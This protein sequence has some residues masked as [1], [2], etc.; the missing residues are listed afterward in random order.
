MSNERTF[1]SFLNLFQRNQTPQRNVVPQNNDD[2]EE[3]PLVI[4]E[5][6]EMKRGRHENLPTSGSM[7]QLPVPSQFPGMPSNMP[8]G[9]NQYMLLQVIIYFPLCFHRKILILFKRMS[10]YQFPVMPSNV[11]GSTNTCCFGYVLSLSK[12]L[13]FIQGFKSTTLLKVKKCQNGTFEPLHEIQKK[14]GPKAFF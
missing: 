4:N 2:D 14:I 3:S 13:N 12:I 7:P 8:A 9:F 1:F 10:R 5:E 11:V 6:P